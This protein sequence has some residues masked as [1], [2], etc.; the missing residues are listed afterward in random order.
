[1]AL[2]VCKAGHLVATGTTVITTRC[3]RVYNEYIMSHFIAEISYGS[4]SYIVTVNT[5]WEHRSVTLVLK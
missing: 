1:M 5:N 2:C 3:V 4:L